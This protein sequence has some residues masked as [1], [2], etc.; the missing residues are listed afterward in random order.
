[1][2]IALDA[3]YSLGPALTGVG[4]YS[5]E[6]LH[7][8]AHRRPQA[9]YTFC[10]RSNKFFKSFTDK[11]PPGASRRPF[12]DSWLPPHDLFHGLNQRVPAAHTRRCVNSPLSN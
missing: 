3:T 11:L 1:M 4:V 10:Y 5:R 9:R 8:L 12:T 6:I 2:R 7:G